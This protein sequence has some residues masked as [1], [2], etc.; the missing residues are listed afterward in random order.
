MVKYGT[1]NDV[2]AFIMEPIL[3]NGGHILPPDKEYFKIILTHFRKLDN[4]TGARDRYIEKL[5]IHVGELDRRTERVEASVDKLCKKS[6]NWA[7]RK[8]MW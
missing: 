3:G 7:K 8:K 2:A 5:D 1:Y 6:L 4:H